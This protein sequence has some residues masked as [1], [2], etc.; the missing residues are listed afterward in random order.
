MSYVSSVDVTVILN[1]NYHLRAIGNAVW[2]ARAKWREIGKELGFTKHDLDTLD[3]DAGANLESVLVVWM[4]RGNATIDQLLA[5][6]RSDGVCRPDLAVKIERT[7][8]S[9]KREKLGLL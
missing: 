7:R 1:S 5:V 8:N 6:L 9:T 2:E 3:G 4:R